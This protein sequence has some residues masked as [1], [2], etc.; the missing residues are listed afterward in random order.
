ME[1]EFKAADIK[2]DYLKFKHIC[3]SDPPYQSFNKE[4]FNST[5]HAHLL[6]FLIFG[7]KKNN[8]FQ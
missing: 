3:T 2:I 6:G 7:K 4:Y 1:A 8:I 5:N